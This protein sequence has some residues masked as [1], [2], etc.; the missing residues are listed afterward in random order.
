MT[1]KKPLTATKDTTSTAIHANWSLFGASV[2]T[3]CHGQMSHNGH[4]HFL[5]RNF[6][7]FNKLVP[8]EPFAQIVMIGDGED[9]A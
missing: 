5:G 7:D 8:G 3:R 6:N 1:K 2:L 9:G 4:V